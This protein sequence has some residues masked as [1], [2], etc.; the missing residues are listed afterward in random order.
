MT[1]TIFAAILLSASACGVNVVQVQSKSAAS[2]GWHN[3]HGQVVTTEHG[4]NGDAARTVSDLGYESGELEPQTRI[5]GDVVAYGPTSYRKQ[6]CYTDAE[7]GD[8]VTVST[9]RGPIRT[10]VT[11]VGYRTVILRRKLRH[12]DSGSPVTKRG[13]IIGVA[14]SV[15]DDGT[16]VA[17][18]R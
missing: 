12:G 5:A 18:I 9:L 2:T 11:E 17:R 6:P 10:S 3:E 8:M 4:H 15:S 13:C 1:K 14:Q 7:V 16:T